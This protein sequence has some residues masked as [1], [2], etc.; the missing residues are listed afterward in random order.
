MTNATI[1]V[2]LVCAK[3]QNQ[4]HL[5]MPCVSHE[6]SVP[7]FY[8][9]ILDVMDEVLYRPSFKPVFI[10]FARFI[11]PTIPGI[12][13]CYIPGIKDVSILSELVSIP[14]AWERLAAKILGRRR[15]S[16]TRAVMV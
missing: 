12:E 7:P 13:V 9:A 2:L 8:R 15:R 4:P 6:C 5:L 11:D 3:V 16:S 10:F 14:I 1:P